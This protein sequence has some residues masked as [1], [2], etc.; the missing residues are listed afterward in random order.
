M[1]R[2]IRSHVED[3]LAEKIISD[4]N[5]SIS[6]ASLFVDDEGKLVVECI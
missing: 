1:R 6:I 3:Q 2:Y 4:Y 5:G